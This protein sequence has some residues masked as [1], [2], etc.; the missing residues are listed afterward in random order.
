MN[1]HLQQRQVKLFLSTHFQCLMKTFT[2]N[3]GILSAIILN[4]L[5]MDHI[6]K[7]I[8]DSYQ[9]IFLIILLPFIL[10]D[11]AI[12]IPR[13]YFFKNFGTILLFAL[14]GTLLTTIVTTVLFWLSSIADIFY[15]HFSWVQCFAF[16]AIIA[17][18]DPVAVLS[19]FKEI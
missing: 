14:L 1:K 7:M 18:T 10:F 16:S 4:S 2:I 17:A 5:N 6:L 19:S 15:M 11:S 9:T 12:K 13:R 3:L 8:S